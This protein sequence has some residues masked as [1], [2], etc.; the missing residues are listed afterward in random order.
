MYGPYLKI[1]KSKNG[2]GNGVFADIDIPAQQ[3]IIEVTGDIHTKETMPDP[4]HPAWYQIS[5]KLFIGPSGGKDDFVNH[6]CDPNCYL[7][8][9]GKRAILYSLYSIREG[10]ELTFDYSTTSNESMD[11]WCMKCLC[12]SPKCRKVISGYQY[13]NPDLKAEYES[14]GMVPMYLTN[15]MF[16]WI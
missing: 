14:K 12:G 1:K 6:S 7:Y 13:L 10:V 11:E 5:N 15:P 2:M 8:I 3:P 16:R 9:V 4:D